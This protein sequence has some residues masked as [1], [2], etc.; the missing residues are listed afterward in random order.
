MEK[1]L[2]LGRVLEELKAQGVDVQVESTAE[3]LFQIVDGT[4]NGSCSDG[5]C[6]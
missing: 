5:S 1:S 6:S 4:G 3:E 2:E